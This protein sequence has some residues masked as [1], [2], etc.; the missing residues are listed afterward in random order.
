MAFRTLV[1]SDALTLTGSLAVVQESAAD[2]ELEL[3]S[4][5]EA[6]VQFSFN[7]QT[8]PTE[9]CEVHVQTAPEDVAGSPVWDTDNT[10]FQRVV[11]VNDVDPTLK[12]IILRGP[13][14]VRFKA[15]V[16]D[17]DGTAGGD[18]TTSALT[19]KVR[20]NNVDAAQS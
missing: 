12:S 20:R 1:T 15:Q 13:R 3:S 18:D 17:T 14:S 16:I 9:Y 6:H 8:T 10:P 11:L 4:F 19:I 7:P 2:M 5:E